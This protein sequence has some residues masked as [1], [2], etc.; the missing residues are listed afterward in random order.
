MNLI[1]NA[2][3]AIGNNH[4]IISLSTGVLDCTE[5]YLRQ[6]RL[7]DK[8]EPG[9]FTFVDVTDNGCGMDEETERR[10]FGAFFHNKIYRQRPWNG[11]GAWNNKRASWSN[12]F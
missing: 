10:I 3:E 4:G 5:E 9:R 7:E 12:Y 6:S 1:T 2:A 8:P 11:C